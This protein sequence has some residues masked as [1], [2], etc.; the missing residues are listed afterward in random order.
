MVKV[1]KFMIAYRLVLITL[2]VIH[3]HSL[4]VV[5]NKTRS[6]NNI[7]SL[8]GWAIIGIVLIFAL[9]SLAYLLYLTFKKG[10]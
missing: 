2:I 7:V 10:G 6:I 4:L 8:E 9:S 3:G 1:E 5:V